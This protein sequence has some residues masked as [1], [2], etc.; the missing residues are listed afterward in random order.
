MTAP[1]IPVKRTRRWRAG[2]VCAGLAGTLACTTPP[3]GVIAPA[4]PS[5]PPEAPTGRIV[6][7]RLLAPATGAA[8]RP[9]VDA[10]KPIHL[11]LSARPGSLAGAVWTL[12]RA[13][14]APVTLTPAGPEARP[15]LAPATT[16]AIGDAELVLRVGAATQRWPLRFV[17]AQ[18]TDPGIRAALV[19]CRGGAADRGLAVLDARLDA[20]PA[21]VAHELLVEK[22]RCLQAARRTDEAYAAWVRAA[23][24]AGD[25]GLPSEKARRLRAAAFVAIQARRLG[26]ARALLAATEPLDAPADPAQRNEDGLAR[27]AYDLGLLEGELGNVREAVKQT[28]AAVEAWSALGLES[29]ADLAREWLVYQYQRA[30]QFRRAGEVLAALPTP[31]ASRPA[32]RARFLHNRAWFHLE[33]MQRGTRPRDLAAV[34]GALETAR[35]LFQSLGD[36]ESLAEAEVNLAWVALLQGDRAGAARTLATLERRPGG[37]PGFSLPFVRLLA[38]EVALADGRPAEARAAFERS[39]RAAREES[40]GLDSEERWRALYGQGRALRAAGDAAGA[41]TAFGAALDALERLGRRTLLRE[42]RAG[43]FDD[44]RG[45]VDDAV[46]LA[47]A[48]TDAAGAF[49]IALRTQARVLRSLESSLRP[50]RL[51]ERDRQEWQRRVEAWAR[52]RGAWEAGRGDGRL[53]STRKLAAWEAERA[54]QRVA[55]SAAFDSAYALLDQAAPEAPEASVA[56]LRARLAPDERLLDFQRVAGRVH[57]FVVTREGVTA[58]ALETDAPERVLD[59]LGPAVT[60]A[61]HLYVV[62]GDVPAAR[63]IPVSGILD[64]DPVWR[65]TSVTLLPHAGLLPT[66]GAP[67]TG[68]PVVVADPSANLPAARAEGEALAARY[69]DA[70]VFVGAAARRADVLA[71][72]DGARLFHFSG[73]GFTRPDEPW[74]AH[75]VLAEEQ[76]LTLADVLVS[77]VRPGVVV[78]SGCETGAAAALGEHESVGL[79]DAFLS[80]GARAVLATERT[81]GDAEARAFV[82]R[83]HAAGGATQPGEAWRRAV[84]GGLA[85]GE[86]GAEAFRLFG[87]R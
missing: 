7:W 1:P 51:S 70:R 34:R 39:A 55:L 50:E 87:A 61:R 69:P 13:G 27:T 36:A 11:V 71:A 22:A 17:S 84:E 82:E 4:A 12:E 74:D 14:A 49:E 62:P 37:L 83:F 35:D 45:L 57:V 41:R 44:R 52:A 24:G 63:A 30:G 59:A 73:H 19:D 42:T 60:G 8:P 5:A 67:P 64:R 72:L 77:R 86:T 76:N 31:P 48:R 56:D 58:Q 20:A 3:D 33:E 25:A 47:L 81:V 18:S 78:L 53:L 15:T 2:L 40:G 43:F 46:S 65:T 6:G 16:P 79:P 66:P 38:G 80:A 75:L 54:Q 28:E 68:R 23:E 32:D 9:V 10:E 21:G 29:D 26:E 85:A